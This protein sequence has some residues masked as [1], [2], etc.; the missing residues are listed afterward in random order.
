[1]RF[2]R[3][4]WKRKNKKRKRKGQWKGGRGREVWEAVLETRKNKKRGKGQWKVESGDEV[5]EAVLER[6]MEKKVIERGSGREEE[7]MRFRRLS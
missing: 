1:M 2:R 5:Q 3:L 6:E 4:S 7:V